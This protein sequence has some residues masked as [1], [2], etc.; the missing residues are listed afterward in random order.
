[1]SLPNTSVSAIAVS[2]W[3]VLRQESE[4]SSG[5]IANKVSNGTHTLVK[6]LQGSC[7]DMYFLHSLS[8][9]LNNTFYTK[10]LP[11]PPSCQDNDPVYKAYTD[12]SCTAVCNNILNIIF[13]CPVGLM[14]EYH[15]THFSL[16]SI[17]N[18]VKIEVTM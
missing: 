15:F 9:L 5:A 18:A 16:T 2:R 13:Q 14:Y 3:T 11:F 7:E 1:M 8:P 4:N 12:V 10:R 17:F 6:R